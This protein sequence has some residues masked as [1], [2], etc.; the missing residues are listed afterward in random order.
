M[1]LLER[2]LLLYKESIKDITS[3]IP[4]KVE[5]ESELGVGTVFVIYTNWLPFY[6]VILD[7]DEMIKFAYLTTFLPLASLEAP[8]LKVNDLFEETKLTHLVFEIEEPVA[9]RFF[10][11]LKPVKHPQQIRD[12]VEKLKNLHYGRI[13][14]EFF[15]LEEKSVRLLLQLMNEDEKIIYPPH[16]VIEKFRQ[17][18][19]T[20]AV[21]ATGMKTSRVGDLIVVQDE[22]GM[23]L[24]FPDEYKS[25]SGEIYLFDELIFR[26]KLNDGL[27]I[28]NLPNLISYLSEGVIEI[29]LTDQEN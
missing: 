10:K 24:F 6:G 18:I 16:Q 27:L 20:K 11:A 23:R 25:R 5:L 26:G 8:I 17:L 2:F 12:T 21:A 3:V 15:N 9:K 7:K 19:Q 29:K 14:R 22:L 4:N 1:S 28:R 13:H